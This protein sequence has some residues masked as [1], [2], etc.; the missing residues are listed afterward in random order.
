V[1]VLIVAVWAAGLIG[2]QQAVRR[3]SARPDNL[4]TVSAVVAANERP[5]DTVF[6]IPSET[7]V[8]SLGYPAPFRELRDLALG[9]SPVASGTLTGIPVPAQELAT[10]FAAWQGGAGR[11]GRVWVVRWRNPP[12]GA[13]VTGLDREELALTDGMRLSRRWTVQSVVLSLYQPDRA[14]RLRFGA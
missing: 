14:G 13:P 9:E 4:R 8:V 7:R 2:P 6:F 11:D 10:R 1:P 3:S 5:G 12:P